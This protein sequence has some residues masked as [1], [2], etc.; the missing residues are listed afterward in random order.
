[1]KKISMLILSCL[2]SMSAAT[3]VMAN[4]I[5]NNLD[6]KAIDHNQSTYGEI[7]E[8]C[9]TCG[10]LTEFNKCTDPLRHE[11]GLIEISNNSLS[12]HGNIINSQ[13]EYVEIIR[14]DFISDREI[15]YTCGDKPCTNPMGHMH[16]IIPTYKYT[17]ANGE[18]LIYETT[19]V[20]YNVGDKILRPVQYVTVVDKEFYMSKEICEICGEGPCTGGFTHPHY[21][22]VYYKYTL[23][24]GST[25]VYD[26]RELEYNIGD[27][28]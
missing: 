27:R 16:A 19:E 21:L 2:L 22:V 13:M 28:V 24:D 6:S 15:C 26:S 9:Y 25:V 7:R 20:E 5:S 18:I 10:W 8:Y 14:K 4:T 23:S 17:L 11:H 3:P 1:M 12:K